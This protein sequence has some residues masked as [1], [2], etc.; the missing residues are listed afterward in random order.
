M[1]E[2]DSFVVYS[3]PECGKRIFTERSHVGKRG[4]CP[5]CGAPTTVGGAAAAPKD[6][7]PPPEPPPLTIAKGPDE[8]RKNKRFVAPN[9]TVAAAKGAIVPSDLFAVDDLS[10]GGVCFLTP[11]V[12]DRK[13]LSGWAPPPFKPGDSLSITLN[14]PELFRPR[15]LKAVV[16]RVAAHAHRKE[17]FKVGAEFVELNDA[18]KKELRAIAE[19][20]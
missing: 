19:K 15:T 5:V 3:C 12:K 7:A 4:L 1:K 20:R 10:E 17:L 8:R 9:A 16:R 18:V 2:I 11:G 13:K 14:V 6:T